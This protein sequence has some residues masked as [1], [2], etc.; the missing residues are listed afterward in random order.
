MPLLAAPTADASVL[1]VSTY[2]AD[3]YFG[4]Q[5]QQLKAWAEK[6]EREERVDRAVSRLLRAAT[7]LAAASTPILGLV[8]LQHVAA[9]L[10]GTV[11]GIV[12]AFF[13]IFDVRRSRQKEER[14]RGA[15]ANQLRDLYNEAA[16]RWQRA[17]IDH[18]DAN[19]RRK[20]LSRLIG[21]IAADRK[22]IGREL[23]AALDG[24]NARRASVID[25]ASQTEAEKP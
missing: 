23:E 17:Q 3:Q 4:N 15:A 21:F 22:R 13:V 25:D 10:T 1:A 14:A 24:P 12:S 2:E 7:I 20:A 8:G 5:L 18:A 19:V 9:A 11:T 16:S 6:I